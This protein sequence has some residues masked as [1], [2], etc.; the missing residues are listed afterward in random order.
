MF[1]ITN[2]IQNSFGSPRHCY[3][4]EETEVRHPYSKSKT[5][6]HMVLYT[7]YPKDAIRKLLDVISEFGKVIRNKI[8]TQ[9]SVAYTLIKKV[10]KEKLKK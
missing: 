6:H 3:F 5:A 8:N 9:K 10:Q 7:E 2:F 1:T 4:R